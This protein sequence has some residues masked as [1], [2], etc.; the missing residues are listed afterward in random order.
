MSNHNVFSH[1]TCF[2]LTVEEHIWF[3]A[4]LKGQTNAEVKEELPEM[5]K[6]IALP[7]KQKEMSKNLSGQ[8][9]ICNSF[10]STFI[11]LKKMLLVF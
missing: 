9:L 7:H 5:I 8:I 2:R 4:R 3:Y 6:D 11:F 1:I 10:F